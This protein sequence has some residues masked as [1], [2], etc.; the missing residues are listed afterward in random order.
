MEKAYLQNKKAQYYFIADDGTIE[1]GDDKK[2]LQQVPEIVASIEDL[3]PVQ[4]KYKDLPRTGF[5]FRNDGLRI[6][7]HIFF[8][9]G[10]EGDCVLTIEAGNN[11]CGD[12][13]FSTARIVS[14]KKEIRIYCVRF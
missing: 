11:I 6:L 12:L 9:H 5:I 1:L 7:S 14:G 3:A 8:K 10:I 13:D 4:Q 2:P